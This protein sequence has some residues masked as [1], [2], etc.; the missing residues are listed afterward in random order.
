MLSVHFGTDASLL[1]EIC[2][3]LLFL[4]QSFRCTKAISMLKYSPVVVLAVSATLSLLEPSRFQ[5]NGVSCQSS[6][7]NVIFVTLTLSCFSLCL[8]S[9]GLGAIRSTCNQ[10][11][12]IVKKRAQLRVMAY[13]L[14]GVITEVLLVLSMRV[15]SPHF[16]LWIFGACCQACN[17]MLNAITFFRQSRYSHKSVFQHQVDL[18]RAKESFA[19]KFED[20]EA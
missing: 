18:V 4:L 11:P 13:V 14:N 7:A 19:V 15:S 9:L 12:D 6:D 3:A 1:F 10:E 8:V 17:G 16:P 20:A 2:L 5:W